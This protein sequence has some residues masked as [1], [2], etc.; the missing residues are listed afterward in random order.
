MRLSAKTSPSKNYF[1]KKYIPRFCSL[2][3]LLF[4]TT[5]QISASIT[6]V[7][8]L[9]YMICKI[10]TLQLCYFNLLYYFFVLDIKYCSNV[11]T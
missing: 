1:P 2:M 11:L 4:V 3:S 9:C 10:S 8:F 5:I 6:T 7:L